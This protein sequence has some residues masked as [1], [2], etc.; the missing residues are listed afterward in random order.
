MEHG[1]R[2]R[3][4][5]EVAQINRRLNAQATGREADSEMWE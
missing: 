1:E 4:A 2:Q 3:W 5:E